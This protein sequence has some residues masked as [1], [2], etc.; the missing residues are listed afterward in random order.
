MFI[1]KYFYYYNNKIRA[2]QHTSI[3]PWFT[4]IKTTPIINVDKLTEYI[5]NEIEEFDIF[6]K[7]IQ[8]IEYIY[9]NILTYLIFGIIYIYS[10]NIL[11]N[12]KRPVE[13]IFSFLFF[14]IL[15][16]FPFFYMESD[17]IGAIHLIIY[18][19]AILI[20]FVF[21]T[22][23]TDQRGH[24]T[25]KTN[26]FNLDY[27]SFP[28]FIMISLNNTEIEIIFSIYRTFFQNSETKT[29]ISFDEMNSIISIGH[30]VFL[31]Q[32]FMLNLL[33]VILLFSFLTALEILAPRQQRNLP[34]L[35]P[36]WGS[37]INILE[38]Q[39]T[40]NSFYFSNSL[41]FC[42]F[43]FIYSMYLFSFGLISLFHRKY[44][45]LHTFL[46]IEA[47]GLLI[48]FIFVYT[49]YQ[50]DTI[51]GELF[52][53]FLVALAAAETAIGIA[54]FLI[55]VREPKPTKYF[56]SSKKKQIVFN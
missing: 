30:E 49:S 54:L 28:L 19:G 8:T 14:I 6:S 18:P 24:W 43:C 32:I 38:Y 17:Y 29:Q 56:D 41:I 4:W 36:K 15:L 51:D 33:G 35:F 12:S 55:I 1:K 53:L 42:S 45:F 26:T 16:L 5:I 34:F 11:I 21:A 52:V 37:Y 22:L 40:I 50:T 2:L 3:S 46:I 39:T 10:F 48:N 31:H 23:T 13:A 25:N 20:F 44:A 27:F 9:F 47:L 7:N